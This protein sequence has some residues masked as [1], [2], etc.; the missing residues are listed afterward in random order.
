M[1]IYV[2]INNFCKFFP[3]FQNK[4]KRPHLRF[5]TFSPERNCFFFATDSVAL[6]RCLFKSGAGGAGPG[7]IHHAQTPVLTQ[8]VTN[9]RS[10]VGGTVWNRKRDWLRDATLTRERASEREAARGQETCPCV[11][12]WAPACILLLYNS[13]ASWRTPRRVASVFAW[14]KFITLLACTSY[15]V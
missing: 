13:R 9:H 8:Q 2:Q 14:S 4:W 15:S 10:V 1:F 7:V 11:C 3:N 5:F 6:A 12:A